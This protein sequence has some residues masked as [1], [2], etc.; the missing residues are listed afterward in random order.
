MFDYLNKYSWKEIKILSNKN[1]K[2]L[3]SDIIAKLK[4]VVNNS[5]NS[6]RIRQIL[7]KVDSYSSDDKKLE[8]ILKNSDTIKQFLKWWDIDHSS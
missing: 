5:K 8:V 2:K 4:S 1:A 3:L 7:D 6:A